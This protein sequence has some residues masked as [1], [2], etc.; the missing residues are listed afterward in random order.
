MPKRADTVMKEKLVELKDMLKDIGRDANGISKILSSKERP[1]GGFG[2]IS[3]KELKQNM[4]L[5]H[6]TYYNMVQTVYDI[7]FMAEDNIKNKQF[8]MAVNKLV[9][10]VDSISW[11]VNFMDARSL[12]KT[13]DDIVRNIDAAGRV[14][15]LIFNLLEELRASI[16]VPAAA[17]YRSEQIVKSYIK[18]WMTANARR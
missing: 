1:D 11:D 10:L 16:L 7:S 5:L 18:G 9:G 15:D 4:N 8:L 12:R 6:D 3:N 13:F 17:S 2:K 14:A